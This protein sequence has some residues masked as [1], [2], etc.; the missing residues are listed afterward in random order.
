MKKNYV[1]TF[2]FLLI[3]LGNLFAFYKI[4]EDYRD[5]TLVALTTDIIDASDVSWINENNYF[6]QIKLENCKLKYDVSLKML[7]TI[8]LIILAFILTQIATHTL[9]NKKEKS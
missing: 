2:A 9:H 1:I 5:N 7:W 8:D 4:R 3:I 6:Y